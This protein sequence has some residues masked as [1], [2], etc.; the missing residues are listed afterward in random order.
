MPLAQARVMRHLVLLPLVLGA[1]TG[2]AHAIK[3]RKPGPKTGKSAESIAR[4]LGRM[5]STLLRLARMDNDRLLGDFSDHDGF[6]YSMTRAAESLSVSPP[7]HVTVSPAVQRIIEADARERGLFK[8]FP[9][10]RLEFDVSEISPNKFGLNVRLYPSQTVG[11]P[12]RL[13]AFAVTLNKGR[14]RVVRSW[15]SNV[16]KDGFAQ[17]TGSKLLTLPSARAR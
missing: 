9:Q 12:T 4:T 14:N 17:I 1:L 16:E 13:G 10:A 2:P 15:W 5:K 11:Q 7:A 3:A 8:R 6:A